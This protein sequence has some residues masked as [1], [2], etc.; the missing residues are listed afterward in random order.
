MTV[1]KDASISVL[2]AVLQR[3]GDVRILPVCSF[4]CPQQSA[5]VCASSQ[6]MLKIG[7][8][9]LPVFSCK[10]RF[11]IVMHLQSTVPRFSIRGE[12][13]TSLLLL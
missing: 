3:A 8:G 13:A 1:P 9:A 11:V 4:S 10:E 6:K 7:E 5:A 2:A 12:M